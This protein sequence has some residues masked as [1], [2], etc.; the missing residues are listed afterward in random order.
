MS[1]LIKGALWQDQPTDVYIEGSQIVEV[2]RSIE[3]PADRVLSGEQK[4]LTPGFVNG[5]THAAMTLFRGFGDDMALMPWLQEKIW[6]NEAKLTPEDVYWGA[7]LACLEMIKSGTTSFF[8]M[9]MYLEATADAV[10]EMGL[11]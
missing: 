3:R 2:G 11:R 8:D 1:L 4:A 10:E 5:H 6:P 7:K 9:Y